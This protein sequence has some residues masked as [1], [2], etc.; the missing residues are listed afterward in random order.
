[1]CPL[2]RAFTLIELLVV[3]AIIAILAAILFP[4]F[5]Q[6]REAA[7]QSQCLSN[8]RQIGTAMMMYTGDWDETYPVDSSNCTPGSRTQ[9][10]SKMNPFWR[11]ETRLDPYVKNSQIFSC[12]SA[13]TPPVRWNST[14]QVCERGGWG[15]PDFLCY[16][17]DPVRGKPLSYGFNLQMFLDCTTPSGGGCGVPGVSLAD[18]QLP[19][20]RIMVA[21]SCES[22]MDISRLAFA[23]YPDGDPTEATNGATF[24]AGAGGSR[25][26]I[27]PSHIRHRKGQ[28]ILF[29][30]NHAKFFDNSLFVGRRPFAQGWFNPRR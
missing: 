22:F 27:L 21:D 19:A 2:R 5:A 14:Q 11:I 23:N 7:R 13:T 6:A 1:M 3:I 28:N 24:W 18:V 10:C 26:S 30:D 16:A 17:Q 4:V 20:E 12:S 8:L 9:W 29:L 25:T 15:Y